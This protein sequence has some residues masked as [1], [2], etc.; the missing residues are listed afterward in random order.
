MCPCLGPCSRKREQTQKAKSQYQGLPFTVLETTAPLIRE[1]TVF[2]RVLG[3]VEHRAYVQENEGEREE[4]RE[5][6]GPSPS[7]WLS[8]SSYQNQRASPGAHS[9]PRT[10]F[11]ISGFLGF[12]QGVLGKKLVNSFLF[13]EAAQNTLQF[14]GEGKWASSDVM[15]QG[16][17]YRYGFLDKNNLPRD[18]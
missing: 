17:K 5:S 2:L 18:N 7:F 9:V 13:S 4:G 15:I 3:T 16:S 11:W 10:H 8:Y 6:W 1:E 14:Q 12:E